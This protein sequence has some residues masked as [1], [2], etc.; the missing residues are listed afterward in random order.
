M[1][2]IKRTKRQIE[3]SLMIIRT[4]L[5]NINIL[6]IKNRRFMYNIQSGIL[7]L[8]NEAYGKNIRSSHSKEFYTSGAEGCF[9]DYMRGWIGTSKNYPDGIFHFA[10]AVSKSQ[11]D[12]GVDTLQMLMTLDGVNHNTIIRGFCDL[13]EIKI[14]ELLPVSF[15]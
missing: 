3:D 6:Q 15:K 14:K 1:D 4:R 13:P 10:P 9:D 5:E 11:F 2:M 12:K 8:G 7:I